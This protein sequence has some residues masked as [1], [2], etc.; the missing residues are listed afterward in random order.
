MPANNVKGIT[1]SKNYHSTTPKAIVDLGKDIQMIMKYLYS[2]IYSE[3]RKDKSQ[4]RDNLQNKW[5]SP[6]HKS[7]SRNKM[8]KS[9]SHE[10]RWAMSSP[11]LDLSLNESVEISRTFWG[12]LGKF[13]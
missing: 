9:E 5:H 8:G 10:K 11:L 3:G 1:E 2:A 13:K 7:V 4:R 12:Q 6:V